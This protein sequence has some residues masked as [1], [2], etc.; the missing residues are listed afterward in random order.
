MVFI[1]NNNK[2][3]YCMYRSIDLK[4]KKR[5]KR[6]ENITITNSN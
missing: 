5:I 2:K 1:E 4:I 3:K 6:D